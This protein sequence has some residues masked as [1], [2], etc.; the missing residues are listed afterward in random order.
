M[1]ILENLMLQNLSLS[2]TNI[3]LFQQ[4]VGGNPFPYLTYGEFAIAQLT[5]ITFKSLNLSGPRSSLIVFRD[6]KGI[7]SNSGFFSF[8]FSNQ[9]L[10]S[11][12]PTSSLIMDNFTLN[13]VDF[14]EDASFITIEGTTLKYN[15]SQLYTPSGKAH[16]KTGLM[17]YRAFSIQ[18]SHFQ[19]IF[20]RSTLISSSHPYVYVV[21]NS[22]NNISL[23]DNGALGL[24]KD[25]FPDEKKFELWKMTN[26][27]DGLN[28]QLIG[29]EFD[30]VADIFNESS[31]YVGFCS[32][33]YKNKFQSVMIDYGNLIRLEKYDLKGG[34]LNSE[35]SD[36]SNLVVFKS[37]ILSNFSISSIQEL[38]LLQFS[39]VNKA[40][41]E[42]NSFQLLTNMNGIFEI[43][44][45]DRE[46]ASSLRISIQNNNF[47]EVG[48]ASSNLIGLKVTGP[49]DIKHNIFEN[50][51][52]S[53]DN[54]TALLDIAERTLSKKD[55]SS[56]DLHLEVNIFHNTKTIRANLK[57][58]TSSYLVRA[59]LHRQ[60]SSVTIKNCS[61][62]NL[63][64]EIEDLT[65]MQISGLNVSITDTKISGFSASNQDFGSLLEMEAAFTRIERSLFSN[66][67]FPSLFN[68]QNGLISNSWMG[69]QKAEVQILNST[70]MNITTG[71]M[72]LYSISVLKAAIISISDDS[73]FSQIYWGAQLFSTFASD[74]NISFANST[75]NLSGAL[76]QYA[77]IGFTIQNPSTDIFFQNSVIVLG[78]A[79][80]GSLLKFGANDRRNVTFLNCSI[81]SAVQS[82]QLLQPSTEVTL[83]A[84]SEGPASK[85]L[86]DSSQDITS[87]N[88][89]MRLLVSRGSIILSIQQCNID[90]HNT[91]SYPWIDLLS[92]N[93]SISIQ[94]SNF[95]N[96]VLIPEFDDPKVKY[97]D[98]YNS[99]GEYLTGIVTIVAED[100]TSIGGNNITLSISGT[101]F[102]NV[103]SL[104]TGALSILNKNDNI[105]IQFLIESS[106]FTNLTSNYGP[107]IA[108]FQ[109]DSNFSSNALGISN[110]QI[111]STY[112]RRLGGAIFNN[113][114]ELI[115]NN[116][117][118]DDN[119]MNSIANALFDTTSRNSNLTSL[120]RTVL[121]IGNPTYLQ[122]NIT[123]EA[124]AGL[125]ISN[126]D[127]DGIRIC[128]Y[129][130][131]SY[132]LA[133]V[134]IYVTV[135]DH[136]LNPFPDP[137][138]QVN[139]KVTINNKTY[140]GQCK[141]GNCKFDNRNLILPG[142]AHDEIRI[143]LTYENEYV[144][145]KNYTL[146][147]LR[148]CLPGEHNN[149]GTKACEF[150]PAGKFSL[151]PK[152][153]CQ[154]C[155][156]NADCYGG[157]NLFVHRGYWRS[158]VNPEVIYK[159]NDTQ[160]RCLGG[161]YSN[162][163]LG[164]QGPLCLQCD[165]DKNYA[166]DANTKGCRE[167]P[168]DKFWLIS[169]KVLVWLL[170]FA[171]SIYVLR[172]QKR[173]NKMIISDENSEAEARVK[174]KKAL[175][176]D[177][178]VTYFQV[179]SIVISFKGSFTD[180]ISI[181]G[182]NT[183]SSSG[184][185]YS[186][187]CLLFISGYSGECPRCVLLIKVL[188]TPLIEWLLVCLIH[189]T[190]M[191]RFKFTWKRLRR[192]LLFLITNFML[193]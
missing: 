123:S 95:S 73:L 22:F 184:F 188:G 163:S 141:E 150:C 193:K 152:N 136:L 71:Q 178:L 55:N 133:K 175:Y 112:A 116:S 56:S 120:N 94:N 16:Q 149:T 6:L 139:L 159:C 46:S 179:I 30:A 37:N 183:A 17:V 86:L 18:N 100:D 66:L 34:L 138:K 108:L 126:C 103:S 13:Q 11:A 142:N 78:T 185:W 97:T 137:L 75:L 67:S 88:Q 96:F 181:F 90:L 189:L 187:I 165:Y 93:A 15:G 45:T 50:C 44:K 124:D 68:T 20:I 43:T 14:R 28:N 32:L 164:Y 23:S 128:V 62:R 101:S 157:N 180:F 51:N 135:L 52:L 170:S 161:N 8:N 25:F 111:I 172:S 7:I 31:E 19:D 5:N 177:L 35:P 47:T 70:Y 80:A 24:F 173:Q 106:N 148:P 87:L 166:A 131:T 151:N 127:Y 48:L 2:A 64:N 85:R 92:E 54:S 168:S 10:I 91:M 105:T 36:N 83:S 84:M 9:A 74:L 53:I 77:P 57:A 176:T 26:E 160:G 63:G 1:V 59:N 146:F 134:T 186:D 81:V 33:F 155:P 79:K 145:L 125:N 182:G 72:P 76:N 129:N 3:F 82:S 98:Y 115:L 169:G 38:P 110:S 104:T 171:Y 147:E 140:G 158:D 42:D 109:R 121:A 162:C 191:Y 118:F 40:I 130:A 49:I 119:Y 143:E 102:T 167:C 41:I 113:M 89:S 21:N 174:L 132:S 192:F 99:L 27:I 122:V 65:L 39:L 144:T 156:G 69:A 114:S 154:P 61:L 190:F 60:Q 29:Q 107:G 117:I 12:T 4:T 58:S 153:S